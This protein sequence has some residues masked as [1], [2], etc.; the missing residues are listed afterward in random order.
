MA[1][2]TI[3]AACRATS[4]AGV[5]PSPAQLAALG[6]LLC[7]YHRQAGGELA[8]WS[9][10]VHAVSHSGIDSEGLRESLWF[11]DRAGECCW[12]LYLLPDSDFLAWER[13]LAVLPG[14][15]DRLAHDGIGDRLWR[16]LAARVRGIHW[17]ASLLRL[18]A[19]P[20]GP[21]FAYAR[22]PVLAASLASVSTLG[23]VAARR[24]ARSEGAESEAFVE[25]CC[26]QRAAGAAALAARRGD[27][28]FPLIRLNPREHA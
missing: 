23:A 25:D 21:G 1:G 12:R 26:C 28:V 5:L 15:G 9:Q 17:Q 11:H 18:H 20:P 3:D 2:T 10:A 24:I 13:L 22:Q 19:L 16:R 6:T 7:L 8:G 14:A 27:D 4:T